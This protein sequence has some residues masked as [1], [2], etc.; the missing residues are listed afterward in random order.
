MIEPAN[1]LFSSFIFKN[2]HHETFDPSAQDWQFV[3]TGP[4]SGANGAL[5]WIVFKR[6]VG[7]F[8]SDFPMLN[9]QSIKLHT[10]FAYILSGG[11]SYRSFLPGG[12]FA[13]VEFFES[14]VSPL[15]GLLAM[16]QTIIVEKR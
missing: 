11:F 12:L 4:L 16:F 15:S 2:F 9:C 6:D 8:A 10:P 5:P 14:L 7:K 3:S 1:T 13:I